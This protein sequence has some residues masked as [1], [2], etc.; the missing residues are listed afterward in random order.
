MLGR[1]KLPVLAQISA[2]APGAARAWSLRRA[3][4]EA[5]A[6]IQGALED[7]SAVLLS[8]DVGLSAAVALAG[9][10]AAGGRRVALLECD[11]VQPRLAASL[12]LSPVPGLHEYLRWEATASEILQPLVLAG[13]G[14]RDASAPVVCIVGGRPSAD[15]ATLTGLE[16][17][18]HAT[19]KLRR[20]YDLVVMAGPAFGHDYGSL[21]PLAAQADALIAAVSPHKAKGRRGRELRAELRQLPVALRGAIVVGQD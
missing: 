16:S 21:A 9:A 3:D 5:L 2:P 1:G 13:P 7:H 12:G 17:F 20:A 18:R 10:A 6:K 11:L 19:A 15:A 4:L 14:S 8:G